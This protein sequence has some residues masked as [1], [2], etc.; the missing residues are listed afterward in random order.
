MIPTPSVSASRRIAT[1]VLFLAFCLPSSKSWAE[2]ESKPDGAIAEGAANAPE[3]GAD[4]TP[5]FLDDLW[6]ALS[7]GDVIF[8][9]RVRGE[10]ADQDGLAPSRALTERMRVGYETGVFRGFSALAELEDIR[11]LDDDRYNAAGLNA[12]PRKTVVAD[13]EDTELNRAV[14]R[15]AHEYA[16]AKLGRQRLILD[17]HRFVGNVGWRQN[18][19][20]FDALTVASDFLPNT[21]LFYSY[22]SD[23]NRIFGP[24]SGRDFDSDSHLLNASYT[25]GDFGKLTGF[26]YFL[27]FDNSRANSS[28]T[29]GFRFAGKRDCCEDFAVS[30]ATSFAYQVDG[31]DNPVEYEAVYFFFESLLEK[32]GLGVSGAGYELLGSDNSVGSFRTPLATLHKFNGFTDMFLVTPAAGLQDF[33]L[34][35]GT[36]LPWDV[37]VTAFFH[38][39]W[40]DDTSAELGNEFDLVFAKPITEHIKALAKVAIFDGDADLPD[41]EVY[42]LQLEISF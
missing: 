24:R 30:Y 4:A 6:T 3:G 36:K 37:A 7:G 22:I 20:T 21:S 12:N 33:Y 23:V 40:T 28:D 17:D 38:W 13:P 19:Q 16:T 41:K 27:D 5:K 15:Y 35:A 14:L 39:F 32:K 25:C 42:W 31:E 34:K 2:G 8:N 11:T 10:F 1:V 18:E 26:V 9:L 29:V